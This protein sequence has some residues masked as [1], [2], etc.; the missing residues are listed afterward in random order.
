MLAWPLG[1]RPWC[2]AAA[3]PND[4]PPA[5]NEAEERS[6]VEPG[7]V[8]A[9]PDRAVLR[10]FNAAEK[11]LAEK[12][13]G[14]A[15]RYLDAV[16][17]SPEDFFFQPDT[18]RPI[19][20]SLKQE[21][22]RLI[23]QMPRAGRELYELQFGAQARQL[24]AEAV[25]AR[26]PDRLADIS[27]RFRH[28]EA[29]REATMLSGLDS[30]DRGQPLAAAQTF[31]RLLGDSQS[32]AF[33]PTLSLSAAAAWFQAGMSEQAANVL[34]DLQRR[35][36]DT[37]VLVADKKTPLF[38]PKADP[39]AWLSSQIGTPS[40]ESSLRPSQWA[41][42]RGNPSRSAAAGGVPL[43]RLLWRV[44]NSDHP[45]AE[46]I[47][48]AWGQSY[49]Q[50][51]TPLLPR[52]QPLVVG[53]VV[54]MRSLRTLMAID[55][56]TGKR[57][58]EAPANDP[59]D[60]TSEAYRPMYRE[61]IQMADAVCQ[62]VWRDGIYGELS[63]DGRLVFSIEG[64]EFTTAHHLAQGIMP[65][66]PR[67]RG[68]ASSAVGNR[69]VA[70]EIASGKQ[71]WQ[72]D[73]SAR[74]KDESKDEAVQPG[75]F[76]LGPPLPLFGRL[77]QLAE[78]DSE[79][80]LLAIDASLGELLWS[81]SIAM[82]EQPIT[83][84][85]AR[86]PI[87][88]SPSYA[89]G[90]LVCP[91][92][93]GAMVAVDLAT[94]SLLWGYLY[95]QEDEDLAPGLV[96]QP[97]HAS[98]GPALTEWVEDSPIIVADRVLAAPPGSEWL[99]CLRLKD[100]ALLWRVPR[101]SD[102]YVACVHDETIVLLG[103]E[104]IRAV[105]L[106][107]G[108]PAWN[109]RQVG[110]AQG[111]VPSG[112]GFAAEG[113]YC[114]PLSTAE[115]LVVDI[116][117]GKV[118]SVRKSRSGV[119]PGNLVC[120]RDMV[121]SQ[122]LDGL[123]VFPQREALSRR[124]DAAL[125]QTPDDP[126]AL[127]QRG[128][129]LL[130]AG[131]RTGAID[132]FRRCL[133]L[134]DSSESR[135][136]LRDALL[137]GLRDEFTVFRESAAEIE[138]LAESPDN[139]AD[140]L[141]LMATGFEAAGQWKP[142]LEYYLKLADLRRDHRQLGMM[143]ISPSLS[144]R[145]DR[146]LRA[147]L[148]TFYDTAPADV[149]AMLDSVV[150]DH[151]AAALRSEEV[152]PL[153]YVMACLGWHPAAIEAGRQFAGRLWRAG[154]RLD[155]E[156]ILN[157]QSCL[158]NREAAGAAVALWASL[159]R[160]AG[161][162]E[163]AAACY[164]RLQH[165]FADTVSAGGKTGRELVEMLD[166]DDPVRLWIDPDHGWPLGRVDVVQTAIQR[167]DNVHRNIYPLQYNGGQRPFFTG[168]SAAID[169]AQGRLILDN[170]LGRPQWALDLAADG[171]SRVLL[172]PGSSQVGVDG[173]LMLLSLGYQCIA[174]DTLSG[175]GPQ[176]LWSRP[177]NEPADPD[178][179]RVPRAM[180]VANAR[181]R[182]EVFFNDSALRGVPRGGATALTSDYFCYRQFRHAIA[183]DPAS[184]NTLWIQR[185]LP[186]HSAIFGDNDYLF[187]VEAGQTEAI[188]LRATDGRRLP[189]RRQVVTGDQW[190]ATLGRNVL[191]WRPYDDQ[192]IL[193]L[194]DPWQQ[195]LVWGPHAFSA[196]AR[197]AIVADE[198]IGVME[199]DGRFVLLALADGRKLVDT[200][201]EPEPM[202]H[203][204]IL[205]PGQSQYTLV[206]NS[207]TPRQGRTPGPL[208]GGASRL[209]RSGR[210]YAFGLD[211]ARLWPDYPHGIVVENQQL[212]LDQPGRLPVLVFASQSFESRRWFTSLFILD[213]RTGR[214]LVN[215]RVPTQTNTFELV[216]DPSRKTVEAL[217]QHTSVRLTFTDEPI[218]ADAKPLGAEPSPLEQMLPTTLDAM[219]KALRR[220]AGGSSP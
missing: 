44:P 32:D 120:H 49:A 142:A 151:V 12:R 60:E 80:R 11:L 66:D 79:I 189:V 36:S 75:T 159:L 215:K 182:P 94:R 140:Y 87:A 86:R 179:G 186:L 194:L 201:L 77:Y 124:V 103:P 10:Q 209:I 128:E 64:L 2:C 203:E 6:D 61:P 176:C 24:L 190:I 202:L 37:S 89:D 217:M 178:A 212:P 74:P 145:P 104:R 99:H 211:G 118:I 184:G 136:L 55:L 85:L 42:Y 180:A 50:V 97:L 93:N 197:F 88:V 7:N 165:E 153:E 162:P 73:G 84:D 76:F 137:E 204:I 62:R 63:S 207:A 144:V 192:R 113:I 131:D 115:V 213:K 155:A 185:D 5:A 167:P 14:E 51:D 195:R 56:A 81:Q 15:I 143:Q 152:A 72:R 210:L 58:W 122:N 110:L 148:E 161:M 109:G 83:H 168:K 70:H 8:F 220:A 91:T 170:G 48:V 13:Y 30:F 35:D 78:C 121:L 129:I 31:Q 208:R 41:M 43:L 158:S 191:V 27:R 173:H 82:V 59:L 139:R 17:D 96:A 47:L 172:H 28:T 18:G 25:E 23:G 134:A 193:E 133:A 135:I 34:R 105:R 132:C 206:T 175:D 4:G 57:L 19:Y 216:G 130:D 95:P 154:R 45:L 1:D 90:V 146:W 199:P 3:S 92:A 157:R 111:S 9:R 21:S 68:P 22:Q 116:R 119:V 102:L 198:A 39:L 188:V 156:L 53:N 183:V 101:Q 174:V 163:D 187:V 46:D 123:A 218:P 117:A 150:S 26:D 171:G 69:L 16:L 149:T 200:R 107:D 126:V 160:D 20:R 164:Q 29:G 181:W 98:D 219:F 65:A 106:S 112:R 54:L 114:L 52:L 147:Q 67:W 100:G 166:A 40:A 177:W 196:N 108:T 141:R 214:T 138:S 205:L 169:P 38:D 125:D 33:E 127:R 71:V